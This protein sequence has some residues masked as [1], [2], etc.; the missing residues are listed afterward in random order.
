MPALSFN[1]QFARLV[2]LGRKRQTIR[3][4]RKRPIK[5]GDRLYLYTGMRTKVCRKLG[6][7][8]CASVRP[9]VKLPDNGWSLDGVELVTWEIDDLLGDDG[10]KCRGDFVE[11]FAQY[12]DGTEF[13]LIMWEQE[14]DNA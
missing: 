12:P 9:L 11:W 6:E 7:A 13:D 3:V 8:D 14:V 5:A 1:K 2:E 10:F 4:K